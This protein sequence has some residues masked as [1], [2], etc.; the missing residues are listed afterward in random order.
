MKLPLL[1]A[2]A[3][4]GCGP[5]RDAQYESDVKY[6]LVRHHVY[7][8]DNGGFEVWCHS[9]KDGHYSTLAK[10]RTAQTNAAVRMAESL[11]WDRYFATPPEQ[12]CGTRIE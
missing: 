7:K 10:A 2:L 1:L 11:M 4:C 12:P 9:V 5:K 3:L 8:C 6:W